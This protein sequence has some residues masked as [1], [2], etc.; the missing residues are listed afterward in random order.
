MINQNFTRGE[1]DFTFYADGVVAFS[2]DHQKYEAKYETVGPATEGAPLTL[3]FTE[4][5]AGGPISVQRK[6]W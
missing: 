4:A 6:W 1:W 3:T 2:L 5:P